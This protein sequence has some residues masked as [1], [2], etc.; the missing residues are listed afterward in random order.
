MS[1]AEKSAFA[2]ELKEKREL[3]EKAIEEAKK[4]EEI[5]GMTDG[6]ANIPSRAAAFHALNASIGASY[7]DDLGRDA[8]A[9]AEEFRSLAEGSRRRSNDIRQITRSAA[10]T[11]DKL[12]DRANSLFEDMN[13]S[14][15]T[16][17]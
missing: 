10:N 12:M 7:A 4:I 6:T 9:I 14:F 8:F 3:L 1:V 15:N 17:K 13:D 5:S 2:V 16:N 11:V